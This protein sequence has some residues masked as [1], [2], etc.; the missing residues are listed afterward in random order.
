MHIHSIL[1][2]SFDPKTCRGITDGFLIGA[3]LP[4]A[5]NDELSV[6]LWIGLEFDEAFGDLVGD[7]DKHCFCVAQRWTNKQDNEL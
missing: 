3:L 1:L 7:A 2:T 6:T 5:L 4:I